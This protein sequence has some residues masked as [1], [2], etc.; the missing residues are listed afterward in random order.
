MDIETT[1]SIVAAVFGAFILIYGVCSLIIK[2]KLYIS[3]ASIAIFCGVLCGPVGFNLINM[4]GWIYKEDITRQFSRIVIAIQVMAAGVSLP[5]AYLK[6]EFRSLLVLLGPVMMFMWMT[7]GL[8]VWY[9]IP[10]L[11]FLE[12]LMIAACFTPT[13]PVLANS[14]VQG[15]FAEKYVP[16]NIRNIII[17]ES[18]AN[19]GLGYPF[20]FLA[21]YLIQMS[22]ATE[23]VFKWSWYI[24]GYEIGFSILVGFFVGYVARKTLKFAEKRDWIDKESF[25]V[26]AIALALFLMGSVGLMG[27]D[28]LLA[29][30]IAGNSFTWD[31]WFREETEDSHLSEVIDM[32]LNLSMFVYIGITMPW[33]SFNNPDTQL[34]IWTLVGL[35]TCVLLFRRLPSIVAL[36]RYIPAIRDWK[37]AMFAGWFGPIGVGALF[38]YTIA[39]ESFP[40]DG[41]TD[42]ARQV[43]EPI[44]YFMI[45]ASVVVHGCTIPFY[46]W[47]SRASRTLTKPGTSCHN[48][49]SD[50]KISPVNS[51]SS[52]GSTE[53]RSVS[54][55]ENTV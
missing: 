35:A 43:I 26:F 15:H 41:A 37:Q 53:H 52:Y 8:C 48:I 7:T 39:I 16:A 32:L 10:N 29:C 21:I 45:L 55:V 24:M 12:A 17:A 20:L 3:E 18:A 31:D 27:S 44:I 22:S 19:D 40:S 28:D 50:V 30:F 11:S 34:T 42:Y 51:A 1:T 49:S 54:V 4:D 9:F 23:A 14:I 36:Y 46:L 6:T 38:Y 13:D 2:Q 25:L 47:G 33:S 5:K